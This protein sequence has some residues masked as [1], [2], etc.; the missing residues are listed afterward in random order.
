MEQP[1]RGTTNRVSAN[2]RGGSVCNSFQGKFVSCLPAK[3]VAGGGS[4]WDPI[5]MQMQIQMPTAPTP[6]PTP[7]RLP[8]DTDI[9]IAVDAS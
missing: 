9:A 3:D 7:Q 2:S 1:D 4:T 6:T 8:P 5:Q